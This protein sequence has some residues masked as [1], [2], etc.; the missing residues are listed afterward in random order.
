MKRSFA[1]TV[2]A[3]MA[4]SLLAQV[5]TPLPTPNPVIGI[6]K[7]NVEKSTTALGRHRPAVSE[8]FDNT[9]PGWMAR[10]SP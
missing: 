8:A 5:P 9:R 7:Q 10:L 6:W 3:L 1:F 4:C 2:L